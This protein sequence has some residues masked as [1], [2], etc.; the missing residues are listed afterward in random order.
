MGHTGFQVSAI[1]LGTVKF[2]RNSGVNYPRSFELPS[3]TEARQLLDL[4]KGLG[5]NLLDTAP[6]YGCAEERLGFL[7]SKDRNDWVIVSKVGEEFSDGQS[8]FDFTPEYTRLSVERSLARLRCDCIDVV[9]VHSNGEDLAILHHYGTLEALAELK[10]RGLVGSY[11]ISI[12]TL[13][14]GL[15]AAAT[16]DVLM[17]TYNPA[18]RIEEPVLKA[19]HEHSTGVLIKK[20]LSSGH[21]DSTE[22]DPVQASMNLSLRHCATS[23]VIVGTLSSDHLRSNVIAAHNALTT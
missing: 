9:L 12:K 1:G 17:V 19:C 20:A 21:L 2:G 15:Q 3:D 14:G 8:R 23:S 13:E 18:H 11:G 10:Q 5:I 6:A 4:A 22:Q 7:L 16:C